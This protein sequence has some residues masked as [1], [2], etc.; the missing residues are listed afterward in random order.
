MIRRGVTIDDRI[1]IYGLFFRSYKIKVAIRFM[2]CHTC[3]E[4]N[5]K[6]QYW[7]DVSPPP[8]RLLLHPRYPS[9]HTPGM[10]RPTLTVVILIIINLPSV[11]VCRPSSQ[12]P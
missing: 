2:L 6:N 9:P 4:I 1:N 3:T 7:H 8:T 5:I 11:S 10:I 12:K